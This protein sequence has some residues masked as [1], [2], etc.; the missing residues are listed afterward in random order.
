[1]YNNNKYAKNLRGNYMKKILIVLI[2]CMFIISMLPGIIGENEADEYTFK[3]RKFIENRKIIPVYT[4]QGLERA[5]GA[6]GKPGVY[7]II[8]Q[9][10]DGA[11]VSGSVDIIIDS[12][13]NP[14]IKI[15]G[16]TVGSGLSY[17]WDTTGYSDGSHTIVATSKGVTDTV[18]VTVN[19]GGGGNTAP[20][21]TITSP[22]NG[23]TVS[24]SVSITVDANDAEDGALI[25]DI[26]IDGAYIT[27]ANS[28]SWDTTGYLDGGHTIRADVED[29]GG[30]TDSDSITV[31]VSNGG[32][33]VNKY[34]LVI[35][36]SDYEGTANDLDYCDDD[37]VD[38]K[39]FLQ[40]EGYSVSVLTDSQA[41]ADN[42]L[43]A[44]GDLLALEDG[45]DYVVLTYSGHGAKYSTYGSCIIS[46]DLYYVTHG[47]IEQEFDSADSQ[48]IYFAFDACEIGG[49]SGLVDNNKVGAFASN[50][51]LSYDGDSSM[52]NGVFTY[53]QMVGW[54]NQNFDN[55][56]DDGNYAVQQFKAWA[57]V[58]RIKV[59]PFVSDMFT[60]P[61]MP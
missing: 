56:E 22:S 3:E 36:I 26:F 19:N 37:A 13:N 48:H 49:F 12:N 32:G 55:F 60:G 52:Q 17:T 11:T 18:V 41:T 39:N 50:R 44:I 42:I 35:G 33:D 7:V 38:W 16:T 47:L 20:T 29:T 9:P 51:R 5:P 1:M 54:D 8:T 30:L 25:A 2:A 15:D 61:M 31:T 23:A 40:G 27:T 6:K 53:Y 4:E 24:G 59:D 43:A 46:H 28:Y 58:R 57:K 14:S 34:A 10:D 45:D 21:V